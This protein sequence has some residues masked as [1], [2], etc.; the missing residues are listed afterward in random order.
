MHLIL[1]HVIFTIAV[2]AIA[3]VSVVAGA[4][5]SSVSIDA[6]GQAVVTGAYSP[7]TFVDI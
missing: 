3:H 7:R 2:D 5:V 1:H 6:F 4:G